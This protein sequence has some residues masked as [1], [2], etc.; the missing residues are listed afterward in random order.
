LI[1]FILFLLSILISFFSPQLH[2]PNPTGQSP[3]PPSF[4]LREGGASLEYHPTMRHLSQQDQ[5]Q[6]LPVRLNQAVQVGEG[7]PM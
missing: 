5:E 1:I 3:S 2:A 7:D 4:F 6:P